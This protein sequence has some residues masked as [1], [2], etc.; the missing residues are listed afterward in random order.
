MVVVPNVPR[1]V[2]LRHEDESREALSW[3]TGW[4]VKYTLGEPT[5]E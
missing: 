4:V 3:S 5:W 2:P 1:M